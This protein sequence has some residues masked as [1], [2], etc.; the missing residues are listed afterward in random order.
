MPTFEYLALDTS[1]KQKRGSIAAESPAAARRQLRTRHLHATKLRPVSEA[2]R[3][4]G[5]EPSKIFRGRRRHV[6]LEFTRQLGTMIDADVNLTESLG[7]LISHTGD[8]KLAQVVQNVR[9]QVVAGD[10]LADSLKQFPEWF[11][12]IYIAMV[13]VGE[14]TGN[15]ARSLKILADYM[16]KRQRLE[17]KIKS[18]L[19]YPIILIVISLLVIVVLM[20]FV[21]P[22][23]T[24]II[25]KSGR[26]LP[27]ITTVLMNFSNM[28]LN[29]WW[30]ILI[31]FAVAW[32]LFLTVSCCASRSWVS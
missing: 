11:D 9:D 10:S 1:G 30:L 5:W 18:A 6:L 27:L 26:P 32:W 14:V 4:R 15:I 22:K 2:A 25:T 23:I 21:V 20:T 16:S 3:A 19:A 12:P 28:L 29:W 8:Q 7:V 13:R 31:I 24:D 17:A